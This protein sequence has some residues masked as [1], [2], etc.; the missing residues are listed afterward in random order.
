MRMEILGSHLAHMPKLGFSESYNISVKRMETDCLGAGQTNGVGALRFR[1]GCTDGGLT[2]GPKR[3]RLLPGIRSKWSSERLGT[4]IR[5]L[6]NRWAIYL[7]KSRYDCVLYRL[8]GVI[9]YALEA[10]PM[11]RLVTEHTRRKEVRRVIEAAARAPWPKH[12]PPVE[13][14][15][16]DATTSIFATLSNHPRHRLSFNP[17]ECNPYHVWNGMGM[18]RWDEFS[19]PR[20]LKACGTSA[21]GHARCAL[22]SSPALSCS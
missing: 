7:Q 16:H 22:R 5:D 15:P 21:L 19:W 14:V 3:L 6:W 4:R 20:L 2:T 13:P 18:G 8:E 17:Q 11:R 1:N 12:E 9:V 10:K